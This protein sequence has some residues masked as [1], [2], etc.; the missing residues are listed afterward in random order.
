[1][2]RLSGDI[3]RVCGAEGRDEMGKDVYVCGWMRMV[4]KWGVCR[5]VSSGGVLVGVRVQSVGCWCRGVE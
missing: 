5:W 3:A 2:H 1:M 4:G